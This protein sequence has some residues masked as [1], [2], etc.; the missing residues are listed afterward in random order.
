MIRVS[1]K[2]AHKKYEIGVDLER[3]KVDLGE[4]LGGRDDIFGVVS[5]G[6]LG[7][8][9]GGDVGIFMVCGVEIRGNLR[10]MDCQKGCERDGG[11]GLVESWNSSVV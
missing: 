8:N 3:L 7:W 5:W 11:V 2:R 1:Q 6:D 4:T 10:G 9:W